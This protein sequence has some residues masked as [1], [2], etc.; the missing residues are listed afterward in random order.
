[1]K[2]QCE[3]FNAAHCTHSEFSQLPAR[4]CWRRFIDIAQMF[5]EVT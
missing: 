1:M 4:V 5:R 2:K 3:T